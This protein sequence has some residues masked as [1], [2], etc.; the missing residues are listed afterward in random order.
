MVITKINEQIKNGY[1]VGI[2]LFSTVLT[3]YTTALN[4]LILLFCSSRISFGAVTVLKSLSKLNQ[5]VNS[6]K[7]PVLT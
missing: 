5:L 1:W 3:I 2:S 7:V 6:T 4:Y